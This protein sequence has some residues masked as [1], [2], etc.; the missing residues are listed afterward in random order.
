[1]HE[2]DATNFIPDWFGINTFQVDTEIP[3]FKLKYHVLE[4][5]D[6]DI[7]LTNEQILNSEFFSLYSANDESFDRS[8][9]KRLFQTIESSPFYLDEDGEMNLT[10]HTYTTPGV[11]NIKTILFRMSSDEQILHETILL[12]TNVVINDA[13]EYKEDFDLFGAVEFSVL[14]LKDNTQELIIGGIS[15]KSKYVKS[16]KV[17][18]RDD[19][20]GSGDYLEKKYNDAPEPKTTDYY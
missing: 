7:K 20:Y 9:A 12:N 11:K 5:G 10:E 2:L 16:L 3:L 4:W 18:E 8:Q 19:L 13:A 14:P 1:M 17:I 6:E 15:E